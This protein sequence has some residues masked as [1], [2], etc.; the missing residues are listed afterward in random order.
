VK[1]N[2]VTTNRGK[3]Q[4]LQGHL[5]VYGIEV[6]QRP[7]DLPE[8]RSSD[9]NFIAQQK[10]IA[11]YQILN[12]PLVVLDAGFYISSLNGFPRAFANFVLE[13][14]GLEGILKLVEGKERT[15][16]FKECLA[17]MDEKSAEP[18]CFL[19]HIEG[20]LAKEPKG[21]M[22]KHL[23]STLA[24]IFIPKHSSLTLGELSPE[25]Y[26]S[27]W[28]DYPRESSCNKKFSEWYSTKFLNHNL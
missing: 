28:R 5:A 1:I 20:S 13:T 24:L 23:W 27:F 26:A 25:E 10:A 16:E 19:S 4:S 14:I 12:E 6:E 2:Y 3:V 21:S 22:Q 7:I 9:V 15:C 17:Y 18:V 11:A 8:P